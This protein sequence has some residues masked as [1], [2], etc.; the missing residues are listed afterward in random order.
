MS[1]GSRIKQRRESLGMTQM[2][3]AQKVGY[4][5]R[6]AITKIEKGV[7]DITQ[8]KLWEFANALRTTPGYL[9]GYDEANSTTNDKFID[10][11]F[12]RGT[13]FTITTDDERFLSNVNKW[14]Q[15]VGKFEFTDDEMEEIMNFAKYLIS[16]RK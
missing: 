3:L 4:T 10:Y 14:I 6:T 2:E 12:E 7:N 1:V 16:K 5:N 11:R 9:L 8:S 15:D 13:S